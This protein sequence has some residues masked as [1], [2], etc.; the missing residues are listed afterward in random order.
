MVESTWP[1]VEAVRAFFYHP[2]S[3]NKE[4]ET[5]V[6]HFLF[7]LAAICML[8]NKM[9][10]Y[11]RNS[12]KYIE[13]ERKITVH[14]VDGYLLFLWAFSMTLMK[15]C[16][17]LCFLSFFCIC[18]EQKESGRDGSGPNGRVDA[19]ALSRAGKNL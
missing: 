19:Y 11:N 7:C 14:I 3:S 18:M 9:D 13:F 16:I 12:I 1:F 6:D 4:R 8:K 5:S 2:R 10:L 17:F 15:I